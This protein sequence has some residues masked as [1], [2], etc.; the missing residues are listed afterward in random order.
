MQH[1]N[2]HRAFALFLAVALACTCNGAVYQ[3]LMA[4]AEGT[5]DAEATAA[6]PDVAAPD[7]GGTGGPSQPESPSAPLDGDEDDELE[8][9][10]QNAAATP[11]ERMHEGGVQA[12]VEPVDEPVAPTSDNAAGLATAQDVTQATDQL[13]LEIGAFSWANVEG[14]YAAIEQDDAG[15]YRLPEPFE[16]IKGLHLVLDFAVLKNDETRTIEEGDFFTF[17]LNQS[18]AG[19][20]PY[21]SLTDTNA[22]QSIIFG[23]YPVATYEIENSVLNVT[24][25]RNVDFSEG[26]ANIQGGISLNFTLNDEAYGTGGETDI[27]LVLQD[28]D[29]PTGVVVPPKSSV[30]D[31]VEKEG[32]Y[33]PATRS[34]VWT[35]K[36]GT[37]S[38]GLDLGGMKIVDTFDAKALEFVSA[39]MV[40]TD[41]APADITSAVERTEG[42]CSYAFPAG[43]VAPQ[44]VQIV[45]KVK[46]DALPTGG[47]SKISNSVVLDEGTSPYKPGD[48]CA[49][50]A[51][52]SVPGMGLQKRGEQIDGNKMQW[53]IVVNEAED[54]WLWDAVVTDELSANLVYTDGS[55]KI[56]GKA[57]DVAEA[58]PSPATSDYAT[59][60][61]NADGTHTLAIH[62]IDADK[63]YHGD[64]PI[65]SKK[66]VITFETSL[67]DD[68]VDDAQVENTASL[69]GCW[70]DGDGPGRVYSHDMGIGTEYRYAFVKKDGVVDQHT[71]VITWAVNPQTRGD[72]ED[73]MLVDVVDASDQTFIDRTIKLEYQGAAW[74]QQELVGK[75][76]LVVAGT[77]AAEYPTT[78]TFT[79]SKS[80]FPTLADVHITYRTQATAG[81]LDG[82]HGQPHTYRN[83]A[84]LEVQ[85]TVGSFENSATAEV[86]L[87][88]DLIAKT[89]EYEYDDATGEGRLHYTLTV[90]ANKMNLRDVV[91][92]DDFS[93]L[94][95]AYYRSDGTKVA[96]IPAS[97][98]TLDENETKVQG[99]SGEKPTLV[100]GLFS[101]NL[102]S[103]LD[104]CTIDLYLA[105]TPEAK[106][107]YLLD[108]GSGYIRTT[109]TAKIQGMCAG[110]DIEREAGS[111]TTP[112]G[113]DIANELVGKSSQLDKGTGI[114]RWR[115]DVNPQGAELKNAVV[116]DVLDKSLQLDTLTVKLYESK[117][118]E[119]GA[120]AQD[121]PSAKGWSEVGADFAVEPGSDG[122]SVLSVKLPDGGKAY[123]LVYETAVVEAVDAG[124]VQNRALLSNDGAE[125]G[126]GSHTQELGEDS[127]G[128]LERTASYKFV[129]MDALGGSAQP[130][131]SGVT[132][133]LFSDADCKNQIKSVTAN[134]HGA[135][136]FYGL[137]AGTSYWYKELSAPDGYVLDGTARELKVPND[138]HGV[139]PGVTQ[140]TNERVKAAGSVEIAKKF[141]VEAGDVSVRRTAT[142]K[143]MLKPLG[144]G[145]GKTVGVA[146]TGSNGTY[147]YAGTS[148]SL[149]DATELAVEATVGAPSARLAIS[150]L[151]WGDYELRET[152]TASGYALAAA[153]K[154]SV[155]KDGTIAFSDGDATLENGKTRITL[156]KRLN[157]VQSAVAGASFSI[158]QRAGST[159]AP[160]VFHSPFTN[161]AYTWTPDGSPWEIV[162]LPAGTYVLRETSPATDAVIAQL[163]DVP[164]TIAADGTLK[165]DES[166]AH[167]SAMGNAIVADNVSCASVKVNKL[168]QFGHAVAGATLQL[169]R[170][171]GEAWENVSEKTTDGTTLAFDGL[172]RGESYRIVETAIPEGYLQAQAVEFSVDAYGTV[173]GVELNNASGAPDSYGNAWGDGAFTLRDERIM[174]HAQFKKVVEGSADAPLAGATFDLYRVVPGDTDAKVNG[175]GSFTSDARGIVTT[176]GSNLTNVATGHKLSEGLAPGTYY[177]VETGAPAG[178]KFD[179]AAAAKSEQFTVQIDGTNRYTETSGFTPARNVMALAS[180]A[181]TPLSASVL[182]HKS[183]EDGSV[184]AG[185][186]FTLAGADVDSKAVSLTAETGSDG[187]ARFDTVPAGSYTVKETKPPAGYRLSDEE[188]A[189]TVLQGEAGKAYDL[190]GT[191]PVVNKQ[192]SIAIDKIDDASS[193]QRLDGAKLKL[194]GIFADGTTE[195]EWTSNQNVWPLEGLL[196]VGETYT[197]TEENRLSTHLGLPGPVTFELSDAGTVCLEDNPTYADGST[198]AVLSGDA[199]A[200]SVRNVRELG[201]ATLLKTDAD[202]G[203][204]LNGVAFSLYD[205]AGTLVRDNLVTGT[206]YQSSDWSESPND[207]G[208][209]TVKGLDPGS[210]RFQETAAAGYQV[211]DAEYPFTIGG[212]DGIMSPSADVGTIENDPIKFSF[213][214]LEL[215]AESCSDATLCT[216]GADATRPLAGAEFKAFEDEACTKAAKTIAGKELTA[217]S[218]ADGLVEFSLFKAGTYYV[219]ETKVPDGC[220]SEGLT[221]Y[222]LDVAADGTVERF[223]PAGESGVLDEI[224]NDVHRT[225]IS[226][227]KVA[228]TDPS[229]TLPNSTYGLFKRMA[230][231]TEPDA[232]ALMPASLFSARAVPGAVEQPTGSADGL[233]LIAKATTDARGMLSFKGVLM[234]QEYV[235]QELAAPDGS[236]VSKN[237]IVMTFAVGKDGAPRLASF[238][239]GS[240]TAEIDADGNIVWNEPQVVIEFAKK[241]PEGDL[242]AGATLQVIDEAGNEVGEA[243]TSSADAPHRVEG[244]LVAGMTYRLVE[245]EAPEGYLLAEDEEFTVDGE[246]AGPGERR[247]QAVEM[248]DQ[249]ISAV[250]PAVG[251]VARTGDP[252]RQGALALAC[253]AVGA[254]GLA[255]ASAMRRRRGNDSK[256]QG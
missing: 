120:V 242:L 102:G 136:G 4:L 49:T 193:P 211:S 17:A 234:N 7:V 151:P 107:T 68:G 44:T 58:A 121:D 186:A 156:E 106:Q 139:Q 255:G 37:S 2:T 122:S 1:R 16:G 9:S 196:I 60:A 209:L 236:L 100:E 207:D 181:N 90:N 26:F 5:S 157:G 20:T 101:V 213:T 182:V 76:W 118:G 203:T 184:L 225:D 95:S 216:V 253:I 14:A 176:V 162:G 87:V 119:D 99:G 233:Q 180:I 77:G 69:S 160:D 224:V 34:I 223:A 13:L 178:Y 241:N 155:G 47:A 45:T 192:T 97:A 230:T 59:L 167:V 65:I 114:I 251:G 29:H 179:L 83:T 57:V 165:L 205:D 135:F 142:F 63:A 137:A 245:L 210:Y 53:T 169:D 140:V 132:F 93:Q 23:G 21:F 133:G 33:D 200:L 41:G 18:N 235:I 71:G 89:A 143:L 88:N 244:L 66:H 201:V 173:K 73:A 222:R 166:V 202:T 38:A 161:A 249:R 159:V 46:D 212:A 113:G 112:E 78:L 35:I 79:L 82:T 61:N 171:N 8:A 74:T 30:V 86:P 91:V 52:T 32:V 75:G 126:D 22:P 185:A 246:K 56:D 214:K 25:D 195:K 198:A 204:P 240:G 111:V 172:K 3:P 51:T 117:H 28:R 31:G 36:A 148:S 104:I 115:V 42:S 103:I 11:G 129:K 146:L 81:F 190:N 217:V 174:G 228:E 40:G 254:A 116:K 150:G 85:T 247:V 187:I 39:S 232:L 229:K 226:I 238:D 153:K 219:K 54:A 84:N 220:V 206:T 197:L 15:A 125:K 80:D 128:Y 96:D 221:T 177:F 6:S 175:D 134:E 48:H 147:A 62:F 168:D 183:K 158:Y 248:M 163:A 127:W 43:A 152:A 237:P 130:L 105:L 27:D 199:T 154:F 138:A 55:L 67:R 145:N 239:D 109:N 72:Y 215:F 92:T 131:G 141:E 208:R 24:F 231:Q 227:K 12:L 70:P 250:K 124:Y 256:G 149:G 10:G 170:K 189:V 243:W 108:S 98:W 123:T 94:A 194:A 191:A 50:S 188:L 144:A 218:D 19:G 110:G 164:F 64:K 252:L